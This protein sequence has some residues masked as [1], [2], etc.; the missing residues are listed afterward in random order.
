MVVSHSALVNIKRPLV[1]TKPREDGNIFVSRSHLASSLHDR[2]LS[3]ICGWHDQLCYYSD[4]QDC[5]WASAVISLTESLFL[6]Q[7]CPSA[8]KT[9]LGF[10]QMV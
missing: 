4:V 6:M 1:W 10:D 3:C 5:S 7:C 2:D 8:Q 9:Q